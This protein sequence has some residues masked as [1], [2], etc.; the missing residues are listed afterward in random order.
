MAQ[1]KKRALVVCAVHRKH[2]RHA[3]LLSNPSGPPQLPGETGPIAA[4]GKRIGRLFGSSCPVQID[5]TVQRFNYRS[6]H[7][8]YCH[9]LL[10]SS[11]K[12]NEDCARVS[13]CSQGPY[14]H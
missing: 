4:F 11:P 8:D 6:G 10:G 2:S 14:T 12:W 13:N 5:A 9:R 1:S 3:L 7:M